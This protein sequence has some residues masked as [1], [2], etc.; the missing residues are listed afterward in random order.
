MA[1]KLPSGEIRS[2]ILGHPSPVYGDLC[3][4]DRFLPAQ[5]IDVS[6]GLLERF[7]EIMAESGFRHVEAPADP[8]G[9]TALHAYRTFAGAH[10]LPLLVTDVPAEASDLPWTPSTEGPR[11][12]RIDLGQRT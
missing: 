4:V 7:S 5:E 10:G 11:F 3:I 12:L 2:F 9:R 8:P 1:D 6:V